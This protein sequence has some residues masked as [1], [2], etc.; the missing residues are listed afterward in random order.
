MTHRLKFGLQVFRILKEK[1]GLIEWLEREAHDLSQ[2]AEMRKHQTEATRAIDRAFALASELRAALSYV[3]RTSGAFLDADLSSPAIDAMR[4]RMLNQFAN[5]ADQALFTES[6]NLWRASIAINGAQ[7]KLWELG[8]T[9]SPR[10]GRPSRYSE[11]NTV[12]QIADRLAALEID[13]AT[14]KIVIDE[15]FHRAGAALPDAKTVKAFRRRR[16]QWRKASVIR[17]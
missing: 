16:D 6:M 4:A 8:E 2:Q 14:T 1:N 15:V 3:Q 17:I 10:R 7:Q 5:E 9:I 11:A 12:A 13:E